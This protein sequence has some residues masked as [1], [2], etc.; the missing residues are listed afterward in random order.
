M[1]GGGFCGGFLSF[2]SGGSWERIVVVVE[3]VFYSK[4]TSQ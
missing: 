2:L 4:E 3:C 1:G